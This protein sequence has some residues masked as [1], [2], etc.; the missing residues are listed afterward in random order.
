MCNA[1]Q[2]ALGLHP[3]QVTGDDPGAAATRRILGGLTTVAIGLAELRNQVGTG[4]GRPHPAQ[5]STDH[6]RLP[7]TWPAFTAGRSSGP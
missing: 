3:S 2:R 4:H 7:S 5:A 1:A 6:A